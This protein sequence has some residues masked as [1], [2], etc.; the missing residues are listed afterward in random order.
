MKTRTLLFSLLFFQIAQIMGQL[1]SE[2]KN[3][4]DSLNNNNNLIFE[5]KIDNDATF[6]TDQYFSSGIQLNVY[7]PVMAKSPFS[8]ILIQAGKETLDYYALTFT[9]NIYTP[10]YID[11]L[12][13]REIDQ[14]F[15]AYILFGNRLESYNLFRR[16]KVTS[17]IQIGVI[18]PMAGGQ[19]FQNTL[20]EHIA[21]AGHVEGWENQISNDICVQYSALLEKGVLNAKWME[22]NIYGG[23]KLGMPNIEAQLG[24]YARIGYFDDYFQNIGISKDKKLQVWLFCAGDVNL[25]AYNAVLQGGLFNDSP[26]TL[27]TIEPF[28]WHTKFGGTLVYKTIK[29]EIAQE[30]ISPSFPT[31]YWFRWAYVSLMVGF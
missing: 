20:H 18:G 24:M 28:I 13:H 30:V 14:P 9:Q 12:S 16:L 17:E 11:T 3:A 2:V 1:H 31:A 5:L 4:N 21:F 10:I 6:F 19:V 15:A 26:Y 22:L 27:Q 25:V 8:K 29:F 23:A 7:A